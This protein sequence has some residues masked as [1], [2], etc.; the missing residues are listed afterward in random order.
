[1]KMLSDNSVTKADLSKIDEKQSRQIQQL[2]FAVFA[3]G[4]VNLLV[5]L[6]FHFF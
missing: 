5:T 4:A 1:M 2:R 3:V 6:L